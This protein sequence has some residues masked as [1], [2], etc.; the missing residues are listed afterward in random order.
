M[1]KNEIKKNQ[2]KNKTWP[3]LTQANSPNPQL[4]SWNYDNFIKSKSKQIMKFNSQ[5]IQR[6]MMK[7][8]KI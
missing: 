4:N 5:S 8:K 1:L 3:E 6:W 7:L 2:L